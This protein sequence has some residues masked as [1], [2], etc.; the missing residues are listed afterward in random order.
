VKG[1]LEFPSPMDA[2]NERVQGEG[3]FG[4]SLSHGR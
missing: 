4:I 1:R 3:A 2:K